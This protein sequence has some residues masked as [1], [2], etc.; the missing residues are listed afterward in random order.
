M[1]IIK[2]FYI[3]IFVCLLF[4]FSVSINLSYKADALSYGVTLY[5]S[6]TVNIDK[7]GTYK[8]YSNSES[9]RSY[10]G[11][12]VN[13]GS[14]PTN[15]YSKTTSDNGEIYHYADS[16]TSVSTTNGHFFSYIT[17]SDNIVTASKNGY[18]KFEATAQF[19]SGTYSSWLVK[20]DVLDKAY[21]SLVYGS[22]SST[23]INYNEF[24]VEGEGYS[25]NNGIAVDSYQP[26]NVKLDK[27]QNNVPFGLC[28]FFFQNRKI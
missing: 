14:I 18:A 22:A 3:L 27:I 5:Q 25:S 19:K 20:K 21:L 10:V 17:V 13:R 16:A 12:H 2:K 4:V 1:K 24:T 23:Q 28:F 11:Y 15:D 26:I 9:I 7:V 8:I 6:N